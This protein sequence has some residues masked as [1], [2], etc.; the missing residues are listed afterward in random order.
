MSLN[1]S[2][3][4]IFL[5]LKYEPSTVIKNTS[6]FSSKLFTSHLMAKNKKPNSLV[7]A[8]INNRAGLLVYTIHLSSPPP[9][10]YT[11][12]LPF[13]AHIVTVS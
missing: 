2:R 8:L 1:K 13:P 11:F 10:C 12:S 3:E 4:N 5:N 6:W 7:K 9:E